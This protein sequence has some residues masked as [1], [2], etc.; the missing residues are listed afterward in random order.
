MGGQMYCFSHV[1]AT[2]PCVVEGQILSCLLAERRCCATAGILPASA[3]PEIQSSLYS[4]V[5]NVAPQISSHTLVPLAQCTTCC[6]FRGIKGWTVR[7]KQISVNLQFDPIDIVVQGFFCYLN[8]RNVSFGK[9]TCTCCY[10]HE[11]SLLSCAKILASGFP[12]GDRR[13]QGA[14]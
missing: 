10:Q 12:T 14:C 4:V 7:L 1:P 8:S 2:L 9:F 3:A 11:F 5:C 13:Q 6:P